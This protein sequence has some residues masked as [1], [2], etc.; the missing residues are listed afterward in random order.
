MGERGDE[1]NGQFNVDGQLFDGLLVLAS[2]LVS[3]VIGLV[4]GRVA[5]F[6]GIGKVI[7]RHWR[8]EQ[9]LRRMAQLRFVEIVRGQNSVG[10]HTV[11]G[12]RRQFVDRRILHYDF[13]I[14]KI[15]F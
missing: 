12:V 5:G 15:Q 9:Q 10:H 11:E 8:L 3:S 2:I 7:H 1:P 14:S 6:A 4:F 13:E